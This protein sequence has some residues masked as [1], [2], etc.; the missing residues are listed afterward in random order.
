MID[1]KTLRKIIKEEILKEFNRISKENSDAI[2]ISQ[3]MNLGIETP[4]V[5]KADGVE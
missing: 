5:Q 3:D 2:P 4:F 1:R